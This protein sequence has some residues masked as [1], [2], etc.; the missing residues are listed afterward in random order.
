[1]DREVYPHIEPGVPAACYLRALEI[2]TPRWS[3]IVAVKCEN[4]C[5]PRFRSLSRNELGPRRS[6][7]CQKALVSTF[8]YMPRGGNHSGGFRT[9]ARIG[10]APAHGAWVAWLLI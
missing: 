4:C 6:G 8:A 1:M 9:S 7:M 2:P 10:A 5:P 3:T